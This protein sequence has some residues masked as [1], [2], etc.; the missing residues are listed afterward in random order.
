MQ[1]KRYLYSP[2]LICHT[3]L[4][5]GHSVTTFKR[6]CM[7]SHV[8]IGF[9]IEADSFLARNPLE[10]NTANR[11]P[12]QKKPSTATHVVNS[13]SKH[14]HTTLTIPTVEFYSNHEKS[15][16]I[17]VVQCMIK[18]NLLTD[19]GWVGREDIRF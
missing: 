12:V 1:D 15:S 14:N 13:F 5:S 19:L 18:K 17:K 7:Y 8:I 4:P 16:P 9:L 2:S 10:N 3:T 6:S 11:Q